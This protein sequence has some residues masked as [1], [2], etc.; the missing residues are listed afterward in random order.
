MYPVRVYT[1]DDSSFPVLLG[2]VYARILPRRVLLPIYLSIRFG[3][4]NPRCPADPDARDKRFD[5][6]GSESPAKKIFT[7]SAYYILF[8]SPI[9]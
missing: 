2:C 8:P 4:T 6:G 5:N 7:T 1:A 9:F 3:V